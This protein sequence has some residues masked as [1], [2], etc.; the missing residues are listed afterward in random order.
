MD[1]I[2]DDQLRKHFSRRPCDLCG[3]YPSPHNDGHHIKSRGSHGHDVE[4]NLVTLCRAH[5]QMIHQYGINKMI[6]EFPRL[7]TILIEKGWYCQIIGTD[8]NSVRKWFNDRI[9]LA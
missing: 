5:H 3:K 2:E 6:A 4:E 1:R 8:K 9:V 7:E